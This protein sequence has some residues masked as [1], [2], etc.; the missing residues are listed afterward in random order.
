M[1]KYIGEIGLLSVAAIW[2][3]GFVASQLSLDS[4]LT[5]FQILTLRFLIS[6]IL[7][8]VI[9]FKKIKLINRDVLKA[10][11]ILGFFLF[12][13]FAFQT[14]G[15]QYTTPSKNAFL[16][17]TN[18]VIVPFIGV[19]IFKKPMDRY[20]IIGAILACFGAGILTL[21][22]NF[23]I[24]IGDLLT[25]VCAIGF[26]LHIFFVGEYV[27]K[28][29]PIL[30]TILQLAGAFIFSLVSLFVTKE[31]NIVLNEKGI[32]AVL[33]LG[34]FSTTLAFLIQNIS[35]KFTNETRSAIILSTESV[36]GALASVIFLKEQMTIKIIIGC[37]LIMAAIT[38]SETKLAFL[39]KRAFDSNN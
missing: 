38:I 21:S 4:R 20:G 26:A 2:G 11:A 3:M 18:V 35:Q 16:T 22:G 39:N 24:N 32:Y 13:A 17:A 10:G 9:Y 33:F 1:K 15:L 14:I 37:I 27:K 23:T 12:I 30:L 31:T 28:F 29:D 6:T 5:P 34:V 8:S 19:A 36:F 25:L 7:M